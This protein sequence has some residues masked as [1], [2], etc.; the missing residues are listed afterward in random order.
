[1][2][3][4]LYTPGNRKREQINDISIIEVLDDSN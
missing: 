3:E 1:M 4:I 2:G